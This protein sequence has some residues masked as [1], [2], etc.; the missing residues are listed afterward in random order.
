MIV[1][2]PVLIFTAESLQTAVSAWTWLLS[3]RAD[4]H[5]EIMTEMSDA[6]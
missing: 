1:W 5:L 4:L 6:W 2:S 3:A